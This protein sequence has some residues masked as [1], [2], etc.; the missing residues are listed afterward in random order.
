MDYRTT[1]YGLSPLL[2]KNGI[3]SELILYLKSIEG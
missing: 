3:I 2:N 1:D